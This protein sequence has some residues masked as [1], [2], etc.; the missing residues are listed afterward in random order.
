MAT[1]RLGRRLR[2]ERA[3]DSM[4]DGQFTVLHTLKASGPHTLGELADR[5]R[6]TA[7]SMNR[8]VNC[9]EEEGWVTRTPDEVDRRKVNIEI[10]DE[11]QALVTAAL[12][13]RDRWLAAAMAELTPRQRKTL[14]EAAAIMNEVATR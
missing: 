7:P 11:G 4:S 8:T 12:R 6:V 10:T 2:S 3:L 9:L 14:T 5:E 13:R 1:F